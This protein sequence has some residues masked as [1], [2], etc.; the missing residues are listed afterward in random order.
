[1]NRRR[2]SNRSPRSDQKDEENLVSVNHGGRQTPY[3]SELKRKG[4]EMETAE[5]LLTRYMAIQGRKEEIALWLEVEIG[6]V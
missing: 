3:C 1:M 2:A 5:S 6:G 4:E